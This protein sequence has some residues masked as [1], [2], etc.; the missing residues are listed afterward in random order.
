MTG[1][2]LVSRS[3]RF[4]WRSHLGMLLGAILATAILVGALAVGDSVRYSLRELALSRLQGIHLALH[5]PDRFFRT[6]LVDDLKADLDAPVAPVILLRGT[7]AGDEAR[8]LVLPWRG[9]RLTTVTHEHF[10]PEPVEV[11]AIDVSRRAPTPKTACPAV[12]CLQQL[13]S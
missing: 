7:A 6:Q 1:W 11:F 13:A 2:T 3:L 10:G 5:A 4:Y 9:A 8:V 12:K